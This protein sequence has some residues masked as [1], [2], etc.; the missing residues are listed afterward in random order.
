MYKILVLSGGGVRGYSQLQV[1]KKRELEDGLLDEEYD[2]ICANSVGAINASMIATGK[3]NMYD[4]DGIWPDMAKMI[5]KKKKWYDLRKLPIY[6]RD[7]FYKVWEYLI[8][9]DFKMKD[10]K[11]KL[12]ILSVDY[13]SNTNRFF[14]SWHSD[15][16]EER[17]V[18]VIARSFAA[19]IYFGQYVDYKRMKCWGDG[20]IGYYNFPLDEAKITAE[21][22]GWYHNDN[23]VLI[24]VVGC[25]YYEP[26]NTFDQQKKRKN[27]GQ[28][29]D[30]FNP[31]TGGL[32][33]SQ[34]RLDQIRRMEYLANKIPS[35]KF[36]YW[37][38]ECSKKLDKLDKIEHLNEYRRLG[39]EM[40]KEPKVKVNIK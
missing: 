22:S 5:F 37:D 30:F 17:L 4:L 29:F 6:D 26:K 19:P 23:S 38:M 36:R 15:D 18:D 13:V 39:K 25:L 40:S 20:G 34:S 21:V 31:F 35:I 33:R 7:N 32:A 8:G 16:G 11:T 9:L 10:V 27:I 14:K 12:M 28:V 1:L 24:D 2:L 3:Y